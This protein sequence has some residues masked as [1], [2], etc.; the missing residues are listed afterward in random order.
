M[1]KNQV[2]YRIKERRK[3]MA[4]E[5][6]REKKNRNR[7]TEFSITSLACAICTG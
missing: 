1:E 2:K 5:R 3:K 7:K 4:R 6:E